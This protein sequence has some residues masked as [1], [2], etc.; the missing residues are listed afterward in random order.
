MAI[1]CDHV[2]NEHN[3]AEAI[4]EQTSFQ[5]FDQVGGPYKRCNL[6]SSQFMLIKL[7]QLH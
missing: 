3:A 4:I 6:W 2:K 5:T 1:L 7:S